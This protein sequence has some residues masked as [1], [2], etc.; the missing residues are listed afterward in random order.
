LKILVTNDDSI[1]AA[2]L[3][4]LAAELK[5]VGEVVVV[6]PDREQ[7]AVGTAVTLHQ[8]LRLTEIKPPLA[9]I[10]AYSVEGT[11]AD[12]VILALG[13]LEE[14]GIVFSGINQGANLG[15]DVLISGTIGAALQG[16]FHGLPSVALSVEVGK[17]MHFEVAAQLGGLLAS[18]II[19]SSLTQNM[20][21]NINLPNLPIDK[22]KGVEITR[23]ARSGYND[24]V[25]EG[26][27]GKRKYYWIVR[28]EPR[29][30]MGEGT[31]IRAIKEDKISITPFQ[32]KLS[33]HRETPFI[34]GLPSLLQEL[35][36]LRQGV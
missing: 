3:W 8:P 36:K 24:H 12:S 4:A 17:D 34:E 18:K 31:D 9:G 13:I 10:K 14:V 19:S 30:D 15:G 25:Q 23:L 20:L 26:N 22:I 29:W 32:E 5:K 28:G 7:S 1:Y 6:A 2:G 21:L 33:T 27:D 11:P 16:Y 35:N